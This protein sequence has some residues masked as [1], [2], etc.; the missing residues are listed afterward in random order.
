MSKITV[1]WHYEGDKNWMHQ[2]EIAGWVDDDGEAA[3]AE[4]AAETRAADFEQFTNEREAMPIIITEP[5]SLAGKYDVFLEYVPAYTAYHDR[6]HEIEE[7]E[8][9]AGDT[10]TA[11]QI[12]SA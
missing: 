4:V 11:E 10:P 9:S 12:P 3:A 7:P 6:W 8:Q 2:T 5:K 1:H